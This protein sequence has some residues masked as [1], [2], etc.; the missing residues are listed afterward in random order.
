MKSFDNSI[1]PKCSFFENLFLLQ[2]NKKN[3]NRIQKD[4]RSSKH[5][6][7][8]AIIKNDEQTSN[9]SDESVEQQSFHDEG[10]QDKGKYKS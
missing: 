8:N 5:V 2:Q 6:N 4:G 7:T 3:R 9:A 1:N 10:F